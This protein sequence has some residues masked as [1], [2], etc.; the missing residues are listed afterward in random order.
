[1]QSSGVPN[2]LSYHVDLSFQGISQRT[3]KSRTRVWSGPY[4]TETLSYARQNAY[5][6]TFTFTEL[7]FSISIIRPRNC[8]RM[9]ANECV[10]ST[11]ELGTFPRAVRN[12]QWYW[13]CTR[14]S[15]VWHFYEYH[16]C[17]QPFPLAFSP[18]LSDFCYARKIRQI[19]DNVQPWFIQLTAIHWLQHTAPYCNAP[20]S[21]I[22]SL[23]QLPWWSMY[24]EWPSKYHELNNFL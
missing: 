15:D 6:T 23:A 17:I 4:W 5:S 12:S 22:K 20:R 19:I 7:Q 10:F 8:R 18:V 14:W 13:Q 11:P 9:Q 24:S 3:R 16:T 1:M 2:I 21:Y